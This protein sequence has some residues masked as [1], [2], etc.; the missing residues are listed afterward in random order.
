LIFCI[1]H[2][3]RT[4]RLPL[5]INQLVPYFQVRVYRR[6]KLM[7]IVSW[8]NACDNPGYCYVEFYDECFNPTSRECTGAGPPP[9]YIP[10]EN[11]GRPLLNEEQQG[12]FNDNI[13]VTTTIPPSIAPTEPPSRGAIITGSPTATPSSSPTFD[14]GDIISTSGVRSDQDIDFRNATVDAVGSS[15]IEIDVELQ[16]KLCDAMK[17]H[18]LDTIYLSSVY[19]I[20]DVDCFEFSFESNELFLRR[21]SL[22]RNMRRLEEES[23]TQRGTLKTRVRTVARYSWRSEEENLKRLAG[24]GPLIE[25]SINRDGGVRLKRKLEDR[26]I[27]VLRDTEVVAN[28]TSAPVSVPI[29]TDP[30]PLREHEFMFLSFASTAVGMSIIISCSVIALIFAAFLFYKGMQKG[31]GED[32]QWEDEVVID[33]ADAF[34]TK[35]TRNLHA[36]NDD[37]HT[38]SASSKGSLSQFDR[39]EERG[40]RNRTQ[41]NS[42][43]IVPFDW[44]TWKR[45]AQPQ[46]N[47]T[48]IV[49][50]DWNTW[51]RNAQPQS[52]STEIV[53]FDWN[54]WKRNA[55]PQSNSTEIVPFDWNASKRNSQRVDPEERERIM[56]AK[57]RASEAVP[58]K[59]NA[60]RRTFV[61]RERIIR[62]K[63]RSSEAVP[64]ERNARRRTFEERERITRAKVRSSE[65]VPFERNSGRRSSL[66]RNSKARERTRHTK[67]RSSGAVPSE[68]N[69]GRK[70]SLPLNPKERIRHAKIR[71][72]EAVPP[73]RNARRRNSIPHTSEGREGIMRAKIRSSG[74]VPS[75]KNAR[76]S[77]SFNDQLELKLSQGDR[78]NA[79]DRSLAVDVSAARRKKTMPVSKTSGGDLGASAH[80]SLSFEAQLRLMKAKAKSR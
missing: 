80:T 35:A 48:E 70:N 25:D 42:T 29:P 32:K 39:L 14:P 12:L 28:Q 71:S 59:R 75:E 13:T 7:D 72:T 40:Q 58:P 27:S 68:R 6:K 8:S 53:P 49:P 34:Q 54:T 62:A 64:P 10:P 78:I 38:L 23:R 30:A 41:T 20:D 37:K 4:P 47:S 67:M 33:L 51:K 44:N 9:Q 15:I 73:Q 52:N 16:E 63:V 19:T 77:I 17:D 66:P 76:K 43:E 45:N 55:Q 11:H 56:R 74:A 22:L 18:I 21:R 24:F 61:E 79:N 60:R 5:V 26:D 36:D 57:I 2:V 3:T 31:K 1:Y 46:S 65:A 69:A 50:F